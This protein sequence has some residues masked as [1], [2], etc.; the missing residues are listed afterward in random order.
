M[1]NSAAGEA[2]DAEVICQFAGEEEMLNC[3]ATHRRGLLEFDQQFHAAVV[4]TP[5]VAFFL[6]NQTWAAFAGDLGLA[7]VYA[8]GNFPTLDIEIAAVFPG[9]VK[10][11]P[12]IESEGIRARQ[13]TGF[14][15]SL[16][17]QGE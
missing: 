2:L 17:G 9:L 13:K 12:A 8:F 5:G 1:A 4:E 11:V 3:P 7:K 16:A 6:E 14:F 15:L 10:R